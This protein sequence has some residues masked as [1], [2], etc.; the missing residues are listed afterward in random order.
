MSERQS[1]GLRHCAVEGP[2]AQLG[3]LPC[4]APLDTGLHIFKTF[5]VAVSGLE[6][7]HQQPSRGMKAVLLML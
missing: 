1:K 2:C 4:E 6:V 5:S 7:F 3:T